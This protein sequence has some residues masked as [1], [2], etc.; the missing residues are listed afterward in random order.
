MLD[1]IV[2]KCD[3]FLV[4]IKIKPWVNGQI[5]LNVIKPG[6]IFT[7]NYIF[8]SG[9]AFLFQSLGLYIFLQILFS[10]VSFSAKYMYI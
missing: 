3:V 2:E 1:I 6:Q 10:S 8:L 5:L 4:K 7:T 9:L